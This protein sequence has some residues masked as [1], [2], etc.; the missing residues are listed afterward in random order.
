MNWVTNTQSQFDD[1][2]EENK[3]KDDL[4]LDDVA[5]EAKELN[6]YL[7]AESYEDYVFDVLLPFLTDILRCDIEFNCDKDLHE[8]K[9]LDE[10]NWKEYKSLETPEFIQTITDDEQFSLANLFRVIVFHVLQ[11]NTDAEVAQ[12]ENWRE[13]VSDF[14]IETLNYLTDHFNDKSTILDHDAEA[15][16][17]MQVIIITNIHKIKSD[18]LQNLSIQGDMDMNQ[19]LIREIKK[20]KMIMEKA[21]PCFV[22]AA[23]K[24]SQKDNNKLLTFS[25]RR[26]MNDEDILPEFSSYVK[27]M[28]KKLGLFI[29]W[30]DNDLT[31][32][33]NNKKKKVSKK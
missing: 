24:A 13:G 21:L 26:Q 10:F 23:L 11:I 4:E 19:E 6:I 22:K 28:E 15:A 32:L 9:S 17:S 7:L 27:L 8:I 2:D 29:R 16:Q 5:E 1:S 18:A 3:S 20:K 30:S 12:K 25:L 33:Q 14:L 31:Q